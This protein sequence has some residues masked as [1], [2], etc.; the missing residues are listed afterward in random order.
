M[1]FQNDRWTLDRLVDEA[2][3]DNPQITQ[4]IASLESSRQQLAE[5]TRA[6]WPSFSVEDSTQP[7]PNISCGPGYAPAGPFIC[8]DSNVHNIQQTAPDGA[9]TRLELR[10]AWLVYGLG[11]L[12]DAAQ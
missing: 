5:A 11:P 3:R 7:A 8:A 1:A 4:S 6:W 12:K 9:L 10:M 2:L